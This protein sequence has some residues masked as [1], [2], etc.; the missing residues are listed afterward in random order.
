MEKWVL[1]GGAQLSWESRTWKGQRSQLKQQAENERG[2]NL[3][4]YCDGVSKKLKREVLLYISLHLL[5]SPVDQCTSWR[6]RG[7]PKTWGCYT[8]EGH[9]AVAVWCTLGSWK[10]E[11]LGVE[12]YWILNQWG[13]ASSD[14]PLPP[15]R[16]QHRSV[17]TS[18]QGLRDLRINVTWARNANMWKDM[19]S[20]WLQLQPETV[21]HWLYT[22]LCGESS[23][24]LWDLPGEAFV[25]A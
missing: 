8:V 14:S 4:T 15:I 10:G 12:K 13:K 20:P 5:F 22:S 6:S 21:I 11:G 9:P 16:S 17:K 18:A 24:S 3:I 19:N 1:S 2:K 23:F 25:T 7:S